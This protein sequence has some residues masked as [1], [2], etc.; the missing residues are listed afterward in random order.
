MFSEPSKAFKKFAALVIALKEMA[1]ILIMK[2]NEYS[3]QGV[4]QNRDLFNTSCNDLIELK[5]L[6]CFFAN[7]IYINYIFK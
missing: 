1:N 2:A 4:L 5:S 7:F 6:L 3:N